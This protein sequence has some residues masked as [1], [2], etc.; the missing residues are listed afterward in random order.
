MQGRLITHR[1]L[2]DDQRGRWNHCLYEFGATDHFYAIEDDGL[3]AESDALVDGELALSQTFRRPELDHII[4]VILGGDGES[5]WQIL[6]RSCN[7]GK[8]DQISYMSAMLGQSYNR[9]GHL[10]QLTAGK[11]YAI[12][13][14][15]SVEFETPKGDGRH[16]R[17]FKKEYSGLANPEN[18]H[19]VYS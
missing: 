6:C 7:A 11:R 4:P 8:S 5:N 9:L 2:L 19:A 10:Y 1:R 13:A 12:I 16:F 18:L 3:P 17:V 14:E 15:A